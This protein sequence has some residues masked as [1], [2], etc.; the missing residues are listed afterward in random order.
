VDT[1]ASYSIYP[2][3]SAAEP[4]GPPL[5]SPGG[6][7]IPC[8]GAKQLEICFA[9]QKFVWTF[10]LAKV[11]FAI[12]CADLLKHF[13]LVVDLAASQL[14]DTRTLRRFAAGPPAATD[15][16]P[17]S[18]RGLFATVEVTPPAFR[19]IF[20]QFQDV[21]NA[22]GKLSP[23]KHKTLHHIKTTG[24]PAT[25]RFRRLDTAKLA[26]AKADFA[27]LERDGIIRRSSSTW[28]APL[29]MVVKPDGTRR[30]CGDY[31]RLNL[32]TTPDSY[33]LPNIQDLSARLHGCSIFSKLDLRKG[34]YEI[35][36]VQEGDIYRQAVISSLHNI[37]HPGIRATKRLVTS[38][39]VW[40]RMGA[41]IAEF[42]RS[43]QQCARSKA[44]SAVHTQVQPIELPAKRFSHVHVDLV[45][46]LPAATG[47]FSHLFTIVD[48]STRWG[49]RYPSAGP[50]QRS[51]QPPSSLDGSADL[52]YPLQLL[53]TEE[54]SLHRPFG[55]NF[56]LPL[57]YLTG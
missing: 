55:A 36:P 41:D 54:Y 4:T 19:Q 7:A 43:C 24:P 25:A 10:L 1:G 32:V 20:S 44:T 12:L 15:A 22:E 16:P 31:R 53:Q 33:P 45:G 17:P 11:D 23:A 49:K 8:W 51:V 13:H 18:S 46:P 34:Y 27:K 50:L 9:G 26:A 48:R 30:L 38:R 47:G 42:C 21:A 5:R 52:E 29:H 37:A 56:A 28:S 39:F 14:L 35:P 40:R 3:S 57:V 2:H 6:Q